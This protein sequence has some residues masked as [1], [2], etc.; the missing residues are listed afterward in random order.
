MDIQKLEQ[1]QNRRQEIN[2]YRADL[3]LQP[4]SKENYAELETT[5]AEIMAINEEIQLILKS[6]LKEE[7]KKKQGRPKLGVTKK[8]SLTLP[9]HQWDELETI[10]KL[11]GISLSQALREIIQVYMR[12]DSDRIKIE[13]ELEI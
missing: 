12:L 11:D 9:E 10:M 6:G 2:Q 4:A 7:P 1:L 13:E 5:F 3:L 8:C